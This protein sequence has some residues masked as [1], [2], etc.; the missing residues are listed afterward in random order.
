MFYTRWDRRLETDVATGVF[1]ARKKHRLIDAVAALIAVAVLLIT[2]LHAGA[3]GWSGCNYW[4]DP[5]YVAQD[6]QTIWADGNYSCTTTG[7]R[8]IKVEIWQTNSTGQNSRLIVR[9]TLTQTDWHGGVEAIRTCSASS[10]Y[11][12]YRTRVWMIDPSTGSQSSEHHSDFYGRKVV[13]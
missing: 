2:P 4:A 6:G 1:F 7:T 13:C 9:K 12:D 5:P 8:T 3:T 11:N 10:Y